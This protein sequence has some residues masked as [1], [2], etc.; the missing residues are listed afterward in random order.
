MEDRRRSKRI[1]STNKVWR[2]EHGSFIRNHETFGDFS[3]HGAFLRM[4]GT[5]A[6]GRVLNLR[7]TFPS[8]DTLITCSAV[9]RHQRLGHGIGV[10]FVGLSPET[11]SQIESSI[12]A[13]HF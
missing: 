6:I 3:V 1:G 4:N 13:S 2:N 9:V 8:A 7:F 12:G 10:E 5:Y 11:R